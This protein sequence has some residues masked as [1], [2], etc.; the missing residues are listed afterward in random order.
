MNA[1]GL[2]HMFQVDRSAKDAFRNRYVYNMRR[3]T[4]LRVRYISIL[5]DSIALLLSIGVSCWALV[6]F[7]PNLRPMVLRLSHRYEFWLLLLFLVSIWLFAL[8]SVGYL[9]ARRVTIR[10]LRRALCVQL[11]LF[12]AL[13]G[14]LWTN[15]SPLSI[16]VML[17]GAL[18]L[19]FPTSILGRRALVFLIEICRSS[20]AV[21]HVLVVGS[22]DGA[23]DLVVRLRSAESDCRIVGCLELDPSLAHGS[24]EGIPILGTTAI[25]RNFIFHN[26]VDIV[27]FCVAFDAVPDA[28]ELAT[29]ILELGLQLGFVPQSYLPDTLN[30]SG[31]GMSLGPFPDFPILTLST[32]PFKPIYSL[33]KRLLDIIVSSTAL[34]LLTPLMLA[35]SLVIKLTSPRGPVLHRL[36]H[37]GMNGRRIIGYKFRTMVPNAHS[38][39]Q[40]LMDRNRMTG[41][42]FKIP[43]DPRITPLGRWLRRY[44]LDELPQLYSVLTGELSLVGPRAP[45]REEVER[46]EFGQRRKLCVKPGLTCFWQVNGRSEITDF[47]EWVRLDLEYIRQASFLT[48]LK[49]LLR[50]VPVVV[51]GRG[52]Y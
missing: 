52:A 43:D 5:P 27:I 42:V 3:R 38:L 36:D 23:K 30:V 51:K 24:V 33:F 13:A 28:T 26:A 2:G 37:V 25:L 17:L 22:R 19:F 45:M 41:P 1:L 16:Y 34:F 11:G 49:I 10:A 46:F 14:F 47:S 9:E 18:L 35:I 29:S 21:P 48:D 40:Q 15:A 31:G 39:K 12:G 4:W 7:E 32:V 6:H 50:T 20:S 8:A 44:S